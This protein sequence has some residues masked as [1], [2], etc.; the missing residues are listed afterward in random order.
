MKIELEKWQVIALRNYFG[1]NDKTALEHW[2]YEVFN[3]A[4]K[5]D[6]DE[7]R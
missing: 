4:L 5:K 3:N 6:K 2:A 7:N 1:L